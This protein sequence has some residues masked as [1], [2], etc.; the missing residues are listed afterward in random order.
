MILMFLKNKRVKE[1]GKNK[2]KADTFH[3]VIFKERN[4]KPRLQELRKNARN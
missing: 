3:M 1:K 2:L 4:I